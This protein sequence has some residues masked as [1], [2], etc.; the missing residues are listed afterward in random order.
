MGVTSA[1]DQALFC[2]IESLSSADHATGDFGSCVA[3]RL[4]VKIIR[5]AV[6][7]HGPPKD[8]L[9]VE[10]VCPH[11]EM[12]APLLHHQG[13]QIS[14][15][16]GMTGSAGVIVA[17]R[18]R[19]CCACTAAA[20]MNVKAEEAGLAVLRKSIHIG[21]HQHAARFLIKPNQP[22][23]VWCIRPASDIRHRIRMA[24][25]SIHTI[26][27]LQPMRQRGGLCKSEVL[28]IGGRKIVL[29]I[30]PGKVVV[31]DGISL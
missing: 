10:T 19:E 7:N 22:F 18:L 3:G 11:R 27:S 12:G 30:V 13:R 4:R 17:A 31:D 14:G 26:T 21:Y 8:V 28:C 24:G 2:L 29:D 23:Y 20:L 15:V 1:P 9:H 6:D 25:I 5:A 16:P